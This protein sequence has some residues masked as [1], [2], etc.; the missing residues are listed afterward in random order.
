MKKIVVLILTVLLSAALLMSGC[1]KD[2]PAPEGNETPS[3]ETAAK[4]FEGIT[5]HFLSNGGHLHGLDEVIPEFE[6][7]TGMKIEITTL[8][9]TG[10]YSKL[11][12]EFG[13]G[14]SSFDVIEISCPNAQGYR[15]GDHIIELDEYIEKYNVDMHQYVST[16]VDRHM[17]QYPQT[18]DGKYICFPYN[19][20]IQIL[21]YRGDL[22]EDPEEMA[23]FKS[24]Y[25]YELAPP[26][27]YDEFIDM[28][29]FFTRD[30]DG[31]GE[32]DLFGTM[33]MG[34]NYPSLVGDITPYI[35]AHGGDWVNSDY[36]PV[37]NTAESIA[38][39]QFYY[40][41]WADGLTPPAANTYRWDE[42]NADFQNGRIAMMQIWP[43]S[44]AN[45]ENPEASK[46]AGKIK[47]AVVPGKVP[48]VGGWQLAIPK[49]SPNP[50]AAFLFASWLSSEEIALKRSRLTGWATGAA[51]VYTDPEMREKYP[52]LDAFNESLQYGKG[53]PQIG[54][55][56]SIW[57]IG[58]EEFSRVFAGELTVEESADN[59]Q[60]RL[61]QLMRDG[62]YYE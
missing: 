6:E 60:E 40:D 61:D 7:E 45:L 34:G 57:Q 55:F 56:T 14:T 43:G 32:N 3:T 36:Q 62:G 38:G 9:M 59:M 28:A 5:I 24:K 33:V 27:T 20:D 26:E 21:A 18:A 15:R 49:Y 42:E 47:Y 41:L 29:E 16:Y 46:V 4:P 52:F 30:T 11:N 25:G 58:A 17:I 13:T 2:V 19:A 31:D 53:W 23:N 10:I 35:C 22:F 54:E 51:A 44:V 50:E 1:T 37:I 8:D 39:L 48:T 12:V